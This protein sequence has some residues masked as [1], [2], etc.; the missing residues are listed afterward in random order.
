MAKFYIWPEVFCHYF[1][2]ELLV[3]SALTGETILLSEFAADIFERLLSKQMDFSGL[4]S[5][6]KP[7]Q[8]GSVDI[9]LTLRT[10]LNELS[11]RG[12]IAA[13]ESVRKVNEISTYT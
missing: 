5:T 1:D 4:L 12:F 10:T 3:Y 7:A 8:Y 13:V 9:E 6:I 2:D 11:R